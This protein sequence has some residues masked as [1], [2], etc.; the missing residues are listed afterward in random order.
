M[1][2]NL[3]EQQPPMVPQPGQDFDLLLHHQPIE[4]I[5][6]AFDSQFANNNSNT[7]LQPAFHGNSPGLSMDAFISA[8]S[9]FLP[10]IQGLA[11]VPAAAGGSLSAPTPADASFDYGATSPLTTFV[12]PYIQWPDAASE[13]PSLFNSSTSLTKAPR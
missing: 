2:T 1:D 8:D 13:T 11:P 5:L 4:D 6:A 3:V 10:E 9:S 7:L 12:Q